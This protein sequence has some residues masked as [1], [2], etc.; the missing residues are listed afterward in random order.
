MGTADRSRLAPAG[1]RALRCATSSRTL[2]LSA[3]R[4][5]TSLLAD[6]TS[7]REDVAQRRARPPA[8]A[9]LLRSAV[10]IGSNIHR[11]RRAGSSAFRATIHQGSSRAKLKA[12][13]LQLC[14]LRPGLSEDR[15]AGVG[16][17]PESEE[18]LV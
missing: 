4:L 14:V 5:P 8:G 11:S 16:V 13:L 3:R 1:G 12:E 10:P 15:D 17:F 9:S 7:V 2:V 6:R 18:V